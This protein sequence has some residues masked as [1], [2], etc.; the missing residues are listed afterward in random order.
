MGVLNALMENKGVLQPEEWRRF[1]DD[2][3]VMARL[4]RFVLTAGEPLT[5]GVTVSECDP[6]AARG[7]V[8]CRLTE[9]GVVLAEAAAAV[10][11]TAD[12][13]RD[14]GSVSFGP[15]TCDHPRCLT[16]TLSLD[17]GAAENSYDLW[18][19]P[20][21]KDVEITREGIRTPAGFV[22]F[23]SDEAAADGPAIVVPAAEGRLPAEYCADF[24]CYSMFRDI[25]DWMKKPR[26]VGTMGLC[27]DPAH[28]ILSG[29]PAEK[30]TTPPWY[31]LL[32]H[33]HCE[34]LTEACE[35]PVQMI[36]NV[37]RA[38]RLGVLWISGGRVHTTL[39]LWEAADEPEA[40]ALAGS[41]AAYVLG[42]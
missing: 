16:L 3:V 14:C 9:D 19:F 39:R 10:P 15:L 37:T 42:K 36:D 35:L 23:V 2:T 11:A 24:W 41:I 13:V 4:P 26:P 8:I 32:K 22:A 12:R 27:I 38:D 40:R 20:E 29:F 31:R 17:D 25:S 7:Q 33:A 34:P 28:P 6:A 5:F 1:C 18:L 21:A 30:W